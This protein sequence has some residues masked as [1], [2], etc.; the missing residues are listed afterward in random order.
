MTVPRAFLESVRRHPH[1][2]CLVH[3]G[4][5]WSFLDLEE[6]SNR[7]AHYFLNAGYP[8]GSCVALFMDNRSAMITSFHG[9][10]RQGEVW[11]RLY[12]IRPK[13]HGG[14]FVNLND[15]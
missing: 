15:F 11:I 9:S 13:I 5:A 4:R 12:F 1:R 7:V 8:T 3:E 2:A 10:R 14:Y 6:Y